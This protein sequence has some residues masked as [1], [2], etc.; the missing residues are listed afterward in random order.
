[1]TIVSSH[2][3]H[4]EEDGSDWLQ[5]ELEDDDGAKEQY[6]V[7]VQ[8]DDQA[9]QD[10]GMKRIERLK[11]ALGIDQINEPSDVIGIPLLLTASDDF[12]PREAA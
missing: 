1:M 9:T 6:A 2:I 3:E 8:S 4:D 5:M 7:C 10:R 12:L 11:I